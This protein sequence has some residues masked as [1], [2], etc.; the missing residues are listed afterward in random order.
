[1]R[2]V[3]TIADNIITSLGFTTG[4]NL[5]S[6]EN[7]CT[8]LKKVI[9]PLLYP[10]PVILS[11]VDQIKLNVLF[12]ELLAKYD[13]K[14]PAA[15][16]TRLEKMFLLSVADVLYQSKADPRDKRMILVISSTKGNID[17]LED[18]FKA[19]FNHRRLYLW[20]MA[21]IVASF[22]EFKNPPVIIS[23]ACISGLVAIITAARMIGNGRFDQAI[24]A[25]GDI[26][27]E[28]VISGFQSFQALSPVNCRPFDRDRKGLSLGEG[29]GALLLTSSPDDTAHQPV[30]FSGGSVTND[31]N[32]IS[33]PSRTGEELALAISRAMTSAGISPTEV[34]Y[35][36]AHGTATLYN[37]EM[38]SKALDINVLN[39]VPVN[40]Y[41]G[42]WGHTLGAA[43]VIE[44]VSSIASLRND[45]LYRS[46]GYE[47]PG[48][49]VPL[50]VLRYHESKKLTTCLK[51]ASGFGG[52]NA[53]IVFQK[54]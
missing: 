34:D 17:L 45:R 25:G 41:K 20:E 51:T 29:S 16:Y 21:R 47:N 26:A 28:F 2:P 24:V 37:D 19:T 15:F 39:K 22:F 43:G 11:R 38:E 54:S 3:Y 27:S 14:T 33:G 35:I 44:S 7:G 12:E 48:I 50:N 4:E 13:K 52:C 30:L 31:A 40:S 42:Y 8:G 53:A 46:E 9:D 6:I 32:H 5:A 36:S 1:M 18:R 49:S 23:N 10:E